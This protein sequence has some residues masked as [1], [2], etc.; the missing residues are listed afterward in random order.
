MVNW[1]NTV[2]HG[3]GAA[4]N[5][6]G[7][8]GSAARVDLLNRNLRLLKRQG[9]WTLA[10]VT[11][12][13]NA[14]ATQD[15]RAIDTVP[16][17]RRLLKGSTAPSQQAA[18]MLAL[19]VA[20]RQH[21][22]SRLD[23]DL[24]GKVDDPGAAIMDAA[25]PKIADAF[26]RPQLGSQLDELNSLF[27]RFDAPAGRNG[28]SQYNGWYQYFDRDIRDVLGLPVRQPF[29][30]EFCGHGD[31][32]RCQQSIWRAID[33]AGAELTAA[34]GTPDPAA[35]RA[36]G[37]AERIHFVPGLLP[38]TMRWVNRPSGIQQVISFD[39]HR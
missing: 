6:W 10:S 32:G 33:N 29:H 5:E 20:W 31:L 18:Q 30:N 4:D 27:P 2:A 9:K 1:N 38:T 3:F 12:A 13:M 19:L 28:D 24:D 16:L 22:G 26:M 15:V 37:T 14:A 39:G 7:R 34:Q 35:W 21:G 25:W 17:L 23:S 36:D 11:S 8:N